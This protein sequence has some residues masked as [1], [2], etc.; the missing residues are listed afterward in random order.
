MWGQWWEDREL[1][2][3]LSVFSLC[4]DVDSRDL[5]GPS[6]QVFLKKWEG[7]FWGRGRVWAGLR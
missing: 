5:P 1:S 3:P 2:Q 6:K 7:A 4:T